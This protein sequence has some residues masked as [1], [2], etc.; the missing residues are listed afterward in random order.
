[1]DKKFETLMLQKSGEIEY[2]T[3]YKLY[4]VLKGSNSYEF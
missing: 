1:M 3:K 2:K 4:N